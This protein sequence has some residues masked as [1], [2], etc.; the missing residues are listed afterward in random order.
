M[1]VLVGLVLFGLVGCVLDYLSGGIDGFDFFVVYVFVELFGWIFL[2]EF[3]GCCWNLGF[4]DFFGLY[5]CF[6]M[7]DLVFVLDFL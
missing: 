4:F 2:V 7:F 3:V 1:C 5:G 6:V